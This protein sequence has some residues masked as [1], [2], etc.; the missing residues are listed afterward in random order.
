[1]TSTITELA[2][3]LNEKVENKYALV[4]EISELAKRLLDDNR[5]KQLQDPF[6]KVTTSTEKVINQALYMKSSEIDIG[7]GLI[8]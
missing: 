8:G 1:M 7:D 4:L 6:S 5:I 2:C 3:D